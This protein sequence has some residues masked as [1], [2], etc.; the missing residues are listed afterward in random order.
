[1]SRGGSLRAGVCATPSG[2][3]GRLPVSP[4]EDCTHM[5]AAGTPPMLSLGF[6]A[7]PACLQMAPWLGLISA[8]TPHRTE[9]PAHPLPR[10]R[11]PLQWR[12]P[13]TRSSGGLCAP[14]PHQV[15]ACIPTHVSPILKNRQK[16]L[17]ECRQT[18]SQS[19]SLPQWETLD[20]S[21]SL[22]A[23]PAFVSG[24]G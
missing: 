18:C 8:Q 13:S 24:K 14:W 2:L 23:T 9:H 21:G 10:S 15:Y 20:V 16:P 6:L 5:R 3:I 12:V 4:Q 11:V 7:I 17:P 19:F 1:M 22:P